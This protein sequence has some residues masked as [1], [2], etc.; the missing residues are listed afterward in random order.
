MY[1]IVM[2]TLIGIISTKKRESNNLAI[3][4]YGKNNIFVKQF[5]IYILVYY[6]ILP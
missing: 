5:N 6:E 3:K 2:F 1:M 4:S